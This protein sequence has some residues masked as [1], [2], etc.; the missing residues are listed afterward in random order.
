MNSEDIWLQA[1][2]NAANDLGLTIR[3]YYDPGRRK[4]IKYCAYYNEVSISPT[5]TYEELNHF[6]LGFRQAKKILT[7]QITNQ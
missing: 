5:L 4:K 1:L 7:N 6:L 3:P 2:Q